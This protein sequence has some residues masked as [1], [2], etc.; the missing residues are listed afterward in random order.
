MV[1]S[2]MLAKQ[3]PEPQPAGSKVETA[4]LGVSVHNVITVVLGLYAVHQRPT[5]HTIY[6]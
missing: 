3:Y 1:V 4:P 6:Q 2:P 5:G